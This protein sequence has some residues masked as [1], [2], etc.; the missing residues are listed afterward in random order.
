MSSVLGTNVPKTSHALGRMWI[1]F[2]AQ[3]NVPA[4]LSFP[5]PSVLLLLILLFLPLCVLP[6]ITQNCPQLHPFTSYL[7]L[8]DCPEAT[9]QSY[10]SR[11]RK[12]AALRRTCCK[13]P[14]SPI[15]RTSSL[16]HAL[17]EAQ[18]QKL[19]KESRAQIPP[20]SEQ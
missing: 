9:S 19:D 3:F 8:G 13:H 14:L 10:K 16:K 11:A 15:W 12:W 20:H 1:W 18:A 7:F 17:P 4:L 2:W 6:N 5:S